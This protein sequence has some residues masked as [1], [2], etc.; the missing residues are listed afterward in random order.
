MSATLPPDTLLIGTVTEIDLSAATVRVAVGDI[1][2]MMIPWGT[3]RAGDLR[4]WCPPSEGEQVFLLLPE[5][6]WEAAY[7]AGSLFSDDCPPPDDSTK[8]LLLFGDGAVFSYD[9]DAHVLA[10]DLSAAGGS[11]AMK[12]PAGLSVEGDVTVTGDIGVTGTVTVSEDVIAD[13]ISLVDH[14]HGNVQSG[15][16]K[17]GKPE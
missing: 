10:I 13:G 16:A 11:A 3:A 8:T 9:P 7:V 17:T 12:V 2:T 4:I 1:E 6:D 14:T 15:S 5:G